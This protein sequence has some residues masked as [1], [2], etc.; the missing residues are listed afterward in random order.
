MQTQQTEKIFFKYV[1]ENPDYMRF[2][3][4]RFFDSEEYK[5]LLPKVKEFN[6]R[7]KQ[8]P[9]RHQ[10]FEIIKLDPIV[11]EKIT[12]ERIRIIYETDISSY[13]DQWMKESVEAWIEFKNLEMSIFDTVQYVK[14]TKVNTDNIKDVV[15]TVKSMMVER[16]SLDFSF[17]VG[18]DF[19]D[20]EHHTQEAGTYFSSGFPFIDQTLGGGLYRKAL[21][22]FAGPMKVGKSLWLCNLAAEAI[23]TGT[24]VIYYTLEMSEKKVLQRIGSNLLNIPVKDYFVMA[25]DRIALK[26]RM[27]SLELQNMQIPGKLVIKEFPTSQAA[28]QDLESH[29]AKTEEHFGCEFPL[30]IIDYINIMRNWRNPNSENTYLKIKQLSEDIRAWMV[31]KNKCGITGTQTNKNAFDSSDFNAGSVAESSGLGHTVDGMFGIIQDAIMY[32]NQEYFLKC[33]LN[34]NDGNKNAKKR[35][36]VN[37]NYMKVQEDFNAE[38]IQG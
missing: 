16:N 27:N 33:L 21:F 34:R 22:V 18:T 29:C 30:I 25:Q 15:N 35:F 12:E 38:I 7:Y 6:E 23:R 4:E 17:D 5:L 2:V 3:T 10:I 36:T 13:D 32:A 37:Y 31:R 24:N 14:S 1:L 20:T 26:N 9:S 8:S 28:V 11:S 19:F